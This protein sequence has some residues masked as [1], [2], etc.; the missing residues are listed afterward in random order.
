MQ[1][2]ENAFTEAVLASS[3]ELEEELYNE[4]LSRLPAKDSSTP[5]REGQYWYYN[6]RREN[7]SYRVYSRCVPWG[8][9]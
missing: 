5:Q 9:Q 2:A 4:I 6:Y 7:A 3:K 1:A 8:G